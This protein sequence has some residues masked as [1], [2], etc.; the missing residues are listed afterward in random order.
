MT[1]TDGTDNQ[2][3]LSANEQTTSEGEQGTS[4][5]AKTY[6]ESEVQKIVNDRL[7]QAGRD[8]KALEAKEAALK[9][10]EFSLAQ[11]EK[12]K[13]EE[14]RER[15]RGNPEA[16]SAFEQERQRKAELKT[17]A[18]ARA[19]IERDKMENQVTLETANKL[20]RDAKII[21]LSAKYKI[22]ATILKDLDLDAE[23]TEKVAQRLT[24]LSAEDLAKLGKAPAKDNKRRDSGVTIGGGGGLTGLSPKETLKNI[25]QQLRNK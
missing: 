17:L 8:A 20:L 6:Q 4:N 15:L 21:E 14:E 11:K 12:E 1:I 19:Q 16:L 7:A 2:Q 23:R 3:D 13:D 5:D 22:D 10:R 24:T 25:D 9:E 18:D